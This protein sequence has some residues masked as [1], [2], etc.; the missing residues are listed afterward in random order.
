MGAAVTDNMAL[1]QGTV[2]ASG[3]ENGQYKSR[4]SGNHTVVFDKF[5]QDANGTRGMY[6]VEQLLGDKT[7]P[8]YSFKP[9]DSSKGY[10]GNAGAFHVVRLKTPAKFSPNFIDNNTRRVIMR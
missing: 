5:G 6:V 10:V 4:K 8:V 1:T 3:W 2:L 7:K 9:F